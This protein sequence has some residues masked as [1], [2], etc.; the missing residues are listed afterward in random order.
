MIKNINKKEEIEEILANNKY[1]IIE[2]S[3]EW[4]GP[5]KAL[6]PIIE[7]LSTNFKE[8][9]FVKIDVDK[10]KNVAEEYGISSIPT[11]IYFKEGQQLTER[12]F[13][14]IPKPKII[15]NINNLLSE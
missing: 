6:Y 3:A 7:E 14:F 11:I 4:C 15:T 13:G 2:F 8:I 9:I 5:C 1:V 12:T 10:N